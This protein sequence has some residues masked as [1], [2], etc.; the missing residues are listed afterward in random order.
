[1][2]KIFFVILYLAVNAAVHGQKFEFD[3]LTKYVISAENYQRETAVYSNSTNKFF[4]LYLNYDSKTANLYDLKTNI[5][6]KFE[7]LQSK[8]NKDLF[9]EFKYLV[10]K[11]I[12]PNRHIINFESEYTIV[13]K[14]SIYAEIKLDIYRN[15]K[16]KKPHHSLLLKAKKSKTNLFAIFRVNCLHPFEFTSKIDIPENLVIESGESIN[17]SRDKTKFK[18]ALL[19]DVK[20]ELE[21]PQNQIWE[22]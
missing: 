9:F 20:F 14:D 11:K 7:V 2:K 3:L 5:L 17:G 19:K 13:K 15:S 16:R 4:Y 21:I 12:I 6:Y 8:V 22:D 18:L 10:S 1:M